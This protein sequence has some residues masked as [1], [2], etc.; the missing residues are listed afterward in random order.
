[1]SIKYCGEAGGTK[2]SKIMCFFCVFD[3]M[4]NPPPKNLTALKMPWCQPQHVNLQDS[5]DN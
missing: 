1:M 3:K 5:L 4:H 2:A